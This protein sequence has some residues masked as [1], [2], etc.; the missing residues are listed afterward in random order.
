MK[1]AVRTLIRLVGAGFAV[2]GFMAFAF[3]FVKHRVRN[4]GISVWHCVLGAILIAIGVILFLGSESL[5]E[6]LTDDPDE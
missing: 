1:R 3:E 4:A 6:Q 5:A 2:F